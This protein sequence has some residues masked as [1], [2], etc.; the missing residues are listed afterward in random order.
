MEVPYIF[1]RD[2]FD[3][4]LVRRFYPERMTYEHQIIRD[5][6]KLHRF[7]YDAI[8]FS[9]RIGSGLEPNPEHEEGIQEMTAR[10]TRKRIDI[11]AW[12]GQQATI[13]EVKRRVT[14]A[15]IGQLRAYRH[16]FLEENPGALEPNLLVIGRYSTPDDLRVIAAEGIPVF[17]YD[18]T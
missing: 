2:Q 4:L 7:E 9:V 10:N 5:W 11:L 8:A 17:L 15:V 18:E 13:I 16:L 6:L 3:D 1:S 12:T 14:S